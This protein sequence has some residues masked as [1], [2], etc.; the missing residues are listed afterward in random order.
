MDLRVFLAIVG[1]QGKLLT[2]MG[3]DRDFGF[4]EA[5]A[6]AFDRG[7]QLRQDRFQ[8]VLVILDDL[9]DHAERRF[10]AR[11]YVFDAVRGGSNG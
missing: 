6:K 8:R 10:A 7:A 3:Y 9:E 2:A 1:L 4:R 11:Q 5:L